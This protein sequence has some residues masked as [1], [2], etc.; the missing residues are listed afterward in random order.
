MRDNTTTN[1]SSII[2]SSTLKQ[3]IKF[4]V[5]KRYIR[6]NLPFRKPIIGR[7]IRKKKRRKTY[8]QIKIKKFS[9]SG[10][11][12]PEKS[13]YSSKWNFISC[14]SELIVP[15]SR[16]KLI[17][18]TRNKIERTN[19]N[20]AVEMYVFEGCFWG[21]SIWGGNTIYVY[22]YAMLYTSSSVLSLYMWIFE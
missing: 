12:S 1:I 19:S 17:F 8:T 18:P 10:I 13:I 3:K 2:C 11:T 4:W 21:A 5:H 7:R 16:R 20:M 14:F 22:K 15:N 9:S 6:K